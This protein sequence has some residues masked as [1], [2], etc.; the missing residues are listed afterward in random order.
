MSATTFRSLTPPYLTP[1]PHRGRTNASYLV[2]LTVRRLA[3]LRGE[4][5]D[6]LCDALHANTVRAFGTFG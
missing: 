2:P 5:L 3:E 1:T 4:D 6:E